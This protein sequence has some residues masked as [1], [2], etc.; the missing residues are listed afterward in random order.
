VVLDGPRG[1]GDALPRFQAAAA[2]FLVGVP[3]DVDV[4]LFAHGSAP[5]EGVDAALEKVGGV[6]PVAEDTLGG[7]LARALGASSGDVVVVVSAAPTDATVA[8]RLRDA[9]MSDGTVVYVLPT[10]GEVSRDLRGLAVGS[11]GFV[12]DGDAQRLVAGVDAIIADFSSQY[13]LTFASSGGRQVLVRLEA[14]SVSSEVTVPVE[15]EAEVLGAVVP[16]N[17]R[18][19][20]SGDD[21]LEND[22]LFLA[23]VAAAVIMIVLV[24]RT[25]VRHVR[26][27]LPVPGVQGRRGPPDPQQSTATRRL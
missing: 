9:A 1:E 15:S 12:A 11:G 26:A 5:V 6:R 8:P 27:G 25:A 16:R 4:T 22:G 7:P 23:V 21:E 2:E 17:D 18:R 13:R 10:A 24:A 3:D 14:D 20:S 19:E